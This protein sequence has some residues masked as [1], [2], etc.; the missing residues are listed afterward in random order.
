MGIDTFYI[1]DMAVEKVE[2]M[3]MTEQDGAVF[4]NVLAL[5]SRY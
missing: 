4:E 5:F 2:F 1:G 3:E